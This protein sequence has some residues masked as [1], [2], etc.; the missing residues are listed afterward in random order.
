MRRF[1]VLQRA[2]NDEWQLTTAGYQIMRGELS[3]QQEK[4]LGQMNKDQLVPLMS[5]LG[6]RY[7]DSDSATANIIRRE[8]KFRARLR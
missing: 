6:E 5:F 7:I 2:D 3:K 8:W 1:G 4:A